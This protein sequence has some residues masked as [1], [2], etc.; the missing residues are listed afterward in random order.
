MRMSTVSY[1]N[2]VTV[3][4]TETAMLQSTGPDAE[5]YL[6]PESVASGDSGY[7]DIPDNV[8]PAPKTP[9]NRNSKEGTTAASSGEGMWY[10][11]G[12]GSPTEKV[13]G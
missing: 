6:N 5:D 7:Y 8:T 1:L 4:P 9:E 10:P 13:Y 12:G 2:P 3:Y 11:R